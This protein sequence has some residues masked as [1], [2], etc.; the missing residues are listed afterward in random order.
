MFPRRSA[1][2]SYSGCLVGAVTFGIYQVGR[3]GAQLDAK[4]PANR[5]PD[6]RQ[7]QRFEAI[8]ALN[9]Q[10]R[11][12][13]LSPDLDGRPRERKRWKCANRASAKLFLEPT[14]DFLIGT[15]T[16][17]IPL[18]FFLLASTDLFLR[19][20]VTVLPRFEDKKAA[21]RSRAKS[22][23][24]FQLSLLYLRINVLFRRGD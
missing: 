20:L 12:R 5:A 6:R 13:G 8:H 18:L 1:R 3:T 23:T 10:G 14:Q 17:L 7:V 24:I 16:V 22:S 15:G 11:P 9:G 4:L 21:W 2:C 19:K